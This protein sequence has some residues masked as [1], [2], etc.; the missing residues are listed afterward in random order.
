MKFRRGRHKV[1]FR[2][3][4]QF[5]GGPNGFAAGFGHVLFF[6][7]DF[8]LAVAALRVPP[9]QDAPVNAVDGAVRGWD[10]VEREKQSFQP[11]GQVVLAP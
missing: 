2:P 10:H 3:Q 8:L 6:G 1:F 4:P 5:N 11:M 9:A 7:G